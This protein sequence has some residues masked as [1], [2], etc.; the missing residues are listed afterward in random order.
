MVVA[1]SFRSHAEMASRLLANGNKMA[2]E[3]RCMDDA[4]KIVVDVET[5]GNTFGNNGKDVGRIL[6]VGMVELLNGKRAGKRLRWF[7]NP[8]YITDEE[9]NPRALAKHKLRVDFL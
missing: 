9:Q 6:E 8:G 2:L 3:Q 1:L 7:C 4:R 5:C